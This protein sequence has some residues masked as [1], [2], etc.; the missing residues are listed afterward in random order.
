METFTPIASLIGGI[1]IGLSASAL[2]FLDG[3]I[4]G[5]SGIV[6][7][8][9]SPAKND[10][11]W[12]AAFVIGLI[13]GGTLLRFFSPHLFEIAIERSAMAFAVAGFLVGFGSRLGNG[14]TSGHSVCGVSRLSPRSLV[15]TAVFIL[16]GALTVYVISHVFGGR[17]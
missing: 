13:T 8:L 12:R 5:V 9:V 10:V 7:G 6:G 14:C 3:R 17:L 1:L 15:A 2:L 11:G 4:A 16:V